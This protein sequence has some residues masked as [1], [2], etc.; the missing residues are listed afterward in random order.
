M[1]TIVKEWMDLARLDLL[2][3]ERLCED[4]NL[5]SIVC[6]HAQQCVE[7]SLKGI[8]ESKGVI[9][10]KVHDLVRLYGMIEDDL[11]LEED[12]LARLNEVYIDSRYPAGMG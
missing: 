2:A 12:L 1:K 7:K 5:S 9:P 8:L 3:A 10:P 11:D 6:F 4:H